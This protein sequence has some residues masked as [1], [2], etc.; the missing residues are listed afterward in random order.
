MGV[1]ITELLEGQDDEDRGAAAAR[2]FA[3]DAFNMLYQFL[4]TIRM[5]GR[6]AAPRHARQ[7]LTSHLIGLFSRTTTLMAEGLRLVFVF[8]GEPPR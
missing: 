1:A 3:V 5:A 2:S 4:T 8:D 7:E 6:H